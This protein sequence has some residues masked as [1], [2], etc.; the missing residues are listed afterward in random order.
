[1]E[2]FRSGSGSVQIIMDPDPRGPKHTDPAQTSDTASNP[3]SPISSPL[4]P[5]SLIPSTSRESRPPGQFDYYSAMVLFS[6]PIRQMHTVHSVHRVD[7][8]IVMLI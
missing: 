5:P 8:T 1:M 6:V 7:R 3:S 2:G 4:I